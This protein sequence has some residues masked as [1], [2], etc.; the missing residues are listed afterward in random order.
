MGWWTSHGWLHSMFQR[1]NPWWV[2]HGM[3]WRGVADGDPS[4]FGHQIPRP[5][6]S[7]SWLGA[8]Q[9]LPRSWAV[10][11][12]FFFGKEWESYFLG[13]LGSLGLERPGIWDLA[14]FSLE[15]KLCLKNW[16]DLVILAS[17]TGRELTSNCWSCQINS[18]KGVNHEIDEHDR[19]P[20]CQSQLHYP[21]LSLF[22]FKQ[23]RDY[24]HPGTILKC[25]LVELYYPWQS[26]MDNWYFI[27]LPLWYMGFILPLILPTTSHNY[28]MAM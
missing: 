23:Q 5:R 14:W 18:N 28:I 8:L 17:K 21:T 20:G 15:M 3:P 6:R 19:P 24:H 13:W 11:R 12:C 16:W 22:E 4:H 1:W 2:R 26:I 27:W 10:H 7:G 9:V 25:G